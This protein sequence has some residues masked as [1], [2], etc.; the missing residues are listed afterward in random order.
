VPDKFLDQK[1][2]MRVQSFAS[3]KLEALCSLNAPYPEE[4]GDFFWKGSAPDARRS[5]RLGKSL[6][7]DCRSLFIAGELVATGETRNGVR[8]RIPQAWW[9]DLYP[10]FATNEVRGRTR[11]FTNVEVCEGDVTPAE[12][13]Q[14]ECLAYLKSRQAEGESRKGVLERDALKLFEGRLTLRMFN[15]CYKAVFNRP[16]GRPFRT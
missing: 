7:E 5:Y 4:A 2:W 8:Q 11:R 15:A 3:S 1:K 12:I 6:V 13:T 9:S 10:M 16:R 14:R